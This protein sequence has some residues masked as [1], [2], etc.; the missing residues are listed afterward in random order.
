MPTCQ[1]AEGS[2]H[3]CDSKI[4]SRVLCRGATLQTAWHA[5][6]RRACRPEVRRVGWKYVHFVAVSV[7]PSLPV[8]LAFEHAPPPPI[9]R[10]LAPLP[11]AT[12]L[13]REAGLSAAVEGE[14]ATGRTMTGC[15]WS[16]D[17]ETERRGF[18]SITSHGHRSQS[19]PDPGQAVGGSERTRRSDAHRARC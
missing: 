6:T 13:A 7:H 12:E 11:T 3:C 5:S 1:Q 9:R 17:D 18:S 2:V 4:G 10:T 14:G 16:S 19:R 15:Q 8:G